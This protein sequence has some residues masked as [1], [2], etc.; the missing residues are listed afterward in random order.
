MLFLKNLQKRAQDLEKEKAKFQ[1]SINSINIGFIVTD[2]LGEI[3]TINNAAKAIFCT[4]GKPSS[5]EPN[6]VRINCT[7]NDIAEKLEGIFDIK[8]QIKS[9]LNNKKSFTIKDLKFKNLYLHIHITPIVLVKKSKTIDLEFIGASILVDDVT[10]EKLLERS[11]EDFFSIASHELKTPLS[12]IRGNTEL[13]KKYFGIKDA[14]LN[15]ILNDIHESTKQLIEIVNDFLDISHLEQGKIIFKKERVDLL[16]LI[17]CIVN[18]I[19]P[20]ANKKKIYLKI[21][22]PKNKIFALADEN[23]TNQILINLI[24]NAVKFT[25]KGGINISFQPLQREIKILVK[26]TGIGISIKNQPLI[27]RK[28]ELAANDPLTRDPNRSTGVGLYISKYLA[29]GMGGQVKLEG[30]KEGK[31]STFSLTLPVV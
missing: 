8:S 21:F 1:A 2:S 17:E 9:V 5:N 16:N 24:G 13:I 15:R 30:T 29:E 10:E 23:R 6:L 3:E 22:K 31:G 14:K 12:I 25:E 18:D 19:T 26:D 27:F 4:E 28:F 11:R 7:I 20:I